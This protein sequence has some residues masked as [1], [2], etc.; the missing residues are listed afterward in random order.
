VTLSVEVTNTPDE[1]FL[2]DQ[3][4]IRIRCHEDDME[5]VLAALNELVTA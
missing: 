2:N 1:V 4:E 5:T 3:V